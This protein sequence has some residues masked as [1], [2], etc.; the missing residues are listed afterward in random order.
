[1]KINLFLLCFI[2]SLSAVPIL[3]Q[4]SRGTDNNICEITGTVESVTKRTD[5]NPEMLDVAGAA[6]QVSYIDV[7]IV[8][9]SSRLL[10]ENDGGGTDCALNADQKIQ[11][12]QL[13]NRDDKKKLKLG[14]CIKASTTILSM[15]PGQGGD[16]L[17]DVQTL[18]PENCQ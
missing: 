11:A 14:Q 10:V 12:Y 5:I 4:A 16:W 18:P 7:K 9:S 8:L 13:E 2:F 17:K 15:G 3:A 1:M 6:A